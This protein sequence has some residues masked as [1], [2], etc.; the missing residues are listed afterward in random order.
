MFRKGYYVFALLAAGIL[1]AACGMDETNSG[2]P[3]ST[4]T[5]YGTSQKG[6][7]VKGTEVTLYGMDENLHQT[8]THFS[9]KVNNDKGD[10]SLKKINL[11]DRYAWLNA[12]GFYIDEVTGEKSSQKIALNSLV[13][14]QDLDHVN[15]NVLT[16]LAFDRIRYLVK[17][18][19]PVDEAKRQ[20][21]KEVMAA[22]G[23]S[24]ETEAFDQLDIL[25]DGED[26]AKL[27][28][29][30]LI[31]LTA[32]DMGEVT[33]RLATIAMDI[34]TDGALDDTTL[35]ALMKKNVSMANQ[36]GVYG[37]VRR[38][39]VKL[40]VAEIPDFQK[41]L[42]NFLIPWDSSW[43]VWYICDNQNEIRNVYGIWPNYPDE[44]F[45]ATYPYPDTSVSLEEFVTSYICRDGVWKL[46]GRIGGVDTTGKYG[47]MV[48]KR[49]GHV[50]KTLDVKMNDGKIVTWMASFMVRKSLS[51]CDEYAIKSG[52]GCRYNICEILNARDE[53]T[54]YSKDF[55]SGIK[56]KVLNKEYV[57]GICPGGWHLPQIQEWEELEES[58]KDDSLTQD[59]FEYLKY[60]GE[61]DWSYF[62]GYYSLDP[63]ILDTDFENIIEKNHERRYNFQS[64][65][66]ESEVVSG[67]RCVKN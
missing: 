16:H 25:G 15:I 62:A 59:L 20:A 40:G 14:L 24:E 18:G 43:G 51:W 52:K 23:F 67:V 33:D 13:D 7:F 27:L 9:T 29:I 57:Q 32:K 55:R 2:E 17:Q 41:Y 61:D 10:Y 56:N 22:F 1:L 19:K 31:M 63:L 45:G 3:G 4:R 35:I 8:G 38:N 53:E 5:I 48:D 46:Y 66:N 34:E 37:V 21:E 36:D 60:I 44:Q 49:D 47:T 42:D 39:L 65:I 12:N 26:D 6:P 28:A 54:C 58:I 64:N 50:Y 30:S 11:D